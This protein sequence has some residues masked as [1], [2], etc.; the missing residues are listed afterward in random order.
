V[1]RIIDRD[2]H[3]ME[4]YMPGQDGKEYKNMEITYTRKK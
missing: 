2:T 4:M 1:F 3:V